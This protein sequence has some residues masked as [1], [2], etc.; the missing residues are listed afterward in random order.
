MMC[1]NNWRISSLQ[2]VENDCVPLSGS[3]PRADII[4]L[5]IFVLR[6][7]EYKSSYFTDTADEEEQRGTGILN[8][9]KKLVVNK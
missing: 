9:F 7:L 1:L 4:Q 2:A 5:A 6:M 8:E 3:T